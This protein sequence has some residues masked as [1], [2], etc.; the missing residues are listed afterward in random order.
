MSVLMKFQI[1]TLTTSMIKLLFHG[2][3]NLAHVNLSNWNKPVLLF[4][5]VMYI[6]YKTILFFVFT[7]EGK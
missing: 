7:F 1:L 6:M 5:F 4:H 3:C 2:N